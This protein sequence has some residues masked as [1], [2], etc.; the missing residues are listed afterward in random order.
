MKYY[1]PNCKRQKPVPW[2]IST[3]KKGEMLA[4]DSRKSAIGMT[5][6][7]GGTDPHSGEDTDQE[8]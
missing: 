4:M 2:W 7:M 1:T 8:V 6:V 5:T 3:T